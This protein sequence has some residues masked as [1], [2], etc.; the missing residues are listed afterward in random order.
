MRCRQHCTQ[1]QGSECCALCMATELLGTALG[2]PGRKE[3]CVETAVL[4]RPESSQSQAPGKSDKSVLAV[5][6]LYSAL[7]LHGVK[8]DLC[9]SPHLDSESHLVLVSLVTIHVLALKGH[10]VHKKR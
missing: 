5:H 6:T 8:H 2:L 3:L 4:D 7:S 1:S 9:G 10:R